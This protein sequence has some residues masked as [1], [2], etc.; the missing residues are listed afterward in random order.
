MRYKP[1]AK[2]RKQQAA[3]I[4][5][6]PANPRLGSEERIKHHHHRQR[7][8][9]FRGREGGRERERKGK[10]GRRRGEDGVPA[11]PQL[12]G[13]QLRRRLVALQPHRRPQGPSLSLPLARLVDQMDWPP[14]HS[15]RLM[16]LFE[17]AVDVDSLLVHLYIPRLIVRMKNKRRNLEMAC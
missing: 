7:H 6:P 13:S 1:E 9:D 4:Y 2:Q 3:A 15:L 10:W 14:Y 16:F 17:I 8:S 11:R 12:R 5:P